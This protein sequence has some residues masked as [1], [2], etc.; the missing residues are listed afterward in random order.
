MAL[1]V[2]G[3]G[4]TFGFLHPARVDIGGIATVSES[5]SSWSTGAIGIVGICVV[6]VS[7]TSEAVIDWSGGGTSSILKFEI[8]F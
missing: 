7:V 6:D 5:E 3:D 4:S 1:R 8:F 2:A